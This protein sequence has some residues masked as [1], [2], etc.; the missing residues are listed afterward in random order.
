MIR[1]IWAALIVIGVVVGIATG[2]AQEV[3]DAAL[4]GAKDAA[5]LCISLIGA[6]ALWLGVLQIAQDA[7]L[8]EAIA[9]RMR[10]VIRRLFPGVHKD[11]AAN[12]YITLNL[13]ANMLGMGNAA[14]PFGLKAMKELQALNPDKER[15]SHAMCMLLIINASAV[16]LMPMTV[17]ALRSAAGSAAPAEIVV[18]SLLATTANTV[19]AI[20]AAKIFQGLSK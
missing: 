6:Y 1:Y 17:I 16:Q 4:T 8:V 7:G 2:R 12:G 20:I 14:T 11:S 5:L 13:V 19:V 15:A 10:G 9:K 3:S 18:T